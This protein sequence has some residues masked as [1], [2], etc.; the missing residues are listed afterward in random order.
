[1]KILNN[2][3]IRFAILSLFMVLGLMLSPNA[4][5]I[6][7][8]S[9]ADSQVI[10][11]KEQTENTCGEG[12]T[13]SISEDGV[14]TITGSGDMNSY[15]NMSSKRAP[16]YG[17]LEDI[18]EVVITGGV[19]S[20][21]SYAFNDLK[22]LTKVTL[23]DTVTTIGTYAFRNSG[24]TEFEITE[25]ISTIGKNAFDS[26]K[27]LTKV[28]IPKT[29]TSLPEGLFNGCSALETVTL[30]SGIKEIS[31]NLFS[32][33][34]ALFEVITEG[35]IETIGDTA[36][37]GCGFEKVTIPKSVTSIGNDAYCNCTKLKEV[38]IDADNATY[39][40]TARTTGLF[41]GC[42]ALETAT[43]NSNAIPTKEFTGC[44]ALKN[45]TI[46]E[47]ITEIES[48]AFENCA[49]LK[50]IKLPESLKKI[51][52]SAFKASGLEEITIPANVTCEANKEDKNTGIATYAFAKCN[53]LEKVIFSEGCYSVQGYA[54]SNASY[55]TFDDCANLK[56]IEI[57]ASMKSFIAYNFR[58]S[59]SLEKIVVD[60]KSESFIFE[61]GLLMD[62]NKTEVILA[63]KSEGKVVIPATVK[64][65]GTHAFQY[66][67]LTQA[68]LPDGLETIDTY[69]F[70]SCTNMQKVNLPD[71][72]K[73]ISQNSFSNSGILEVTIPANIT[74]LQKNTFNGCGNLKKVYIP[75]SVTSTGTHV[76]AN[77][78]SLSE[79]RLPENMSTIAS[80]LFLNCTSL[81]SIYLP[82]SVKIIDTN[83]FKGSTNLSYVYYAGQ[84]SDITVKTAKD[85]IN[86]ALWIY[87]Y[88]G[89][90]EN[91]EKATVS[92]I[93]AS[94]NYAQNDTPENLSVTV[95]SLAKEGENEQFCFTWF[96]N[97]KNSN[98][99]GVV[100]K[101]I[102]SQDGLTASCTPDTKDVGTNFYYVS[103]VRVV[104]GY[105][106]KVVV[107]EPVTITV[108]MAGLE[109]EG[110]EKNPFLL[111][112]Q[113]DLNLISSQVKAGN[114]LSGVYFAFANDISLD[115]NWEPIG[116]L[117]EGKTSANSGKDM[118]AFSGCID[119]ANHTL[120]I[121]KGGL[122]L[123]NYA[124][125]AQVKNLNIYGEYIKSSGLLNNYV[126]DYG[127]E[128]SADIYGSGVP[129]TLEVN[130]VTIKS[131]TV[132][133]ES[134]FAD[135]YA[136]GMNLINITNC[137]VEKNV[138]I[139]YDAEANA[140]T[141]RD[142]LTAVGS[143]G[144]RFNGHITNSVSYADVYG[145]NYV[146]GLTG[147]KGQ[148]MGDFVITN[149]SFHGNV[150]ATGDYA[151]GITGAGYPDGS[152]PNTR[153]ADIRNCYSDGNIS[154]NDYVAGIIG[155]EPVISQ[156]WSNGIGYICN[157]V[158]Y[159]KLTATKENAHMGGIISYIKSLNIYTNVD[160]NYFT[161]D[162]GAQKGIGSVLYVDTKA[163]HEN[164]QGVI[165]FSTE[166]TAAGCPEV[167]GCSW[168][169][170]HNR[171]DDPLGA[172]A[173]KLTK[174]VTKEILTN[175]S[176][177]NALNEGEYSS[178]NW[179]QGENA[180]KL[181][182]SPVIYKLEI[183]GDYKKE[184]TT[185]EDFDL[186]GAVVKGY[187]SDGTVKDIP[188]KDITVKGYD[189]NTKGQQIVTLN[190]NGLSLNV[191][192]TVVKPAV[193]TIKV[194][195]VVYGDDIHGGSEEDENIHTYSKRNLKI[196][197]E[198][199]EYEIPE[200]KTVWDLMAVV[201]EKHSNIVF[202]SKNNT[203]D[204]VHSVT[205]NG[206]ELGEFDNGQNSGWMY[207][208]NG[209]YPGVGVNAKYIEDGDQIIF[210]YTDDFT[211]EDEEYVVN[212]A[213]KNA[214][215]ELENYY[216]Y[217]DYRIEEIEKIKSIVKNAKEAINAASTHKAVAVALESAKNSIDKLKTD[218]QYNAEELVVI[219]DEAKTEIGSYADLSKYLKEQ[220]AKVEEIINTAL[221][222]IDAATEEE[223]VEKIL[224]D[225]KEAIDKIKTTEQLN[226]EALELANSAYELTLA[227]K[228][229]A[230]DAIKSANQAVN[231]ANK[232]KSEAQKKVKTAGDAAVK[233]AANYKQLALKAVKAEKNA[234]SKAK[235]YKEAAQ[236]AKNAA[237]ALLKL[238]TKENEEKAN[239]LNTIANNLLVNATTQLNKVTEAK[240]KADS[241]YNA[242][243]KLY[244]QAVKDRNQKNT[245]I[246]RAKAKK[247]NLTKVSILKGNRAS[248]QWKKVSGVSGYEI[249]YSLSSSF[250]TAKKFETRNILVKASE[251]KKTLSKLK[252]NKKY[253]VRVRT[254][255][256]ID[257]TKVY[258]KWSAKKAFTAKK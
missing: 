65:I 152:A 180:P 153:C 14:L 220:A 235:V 200:N 35:E 217:D 6:T 138:K 195:F 216:N 42:I 253:Y 73:E 75:D 39:V 229:I 188:V 36:F 169:I 190:Y 90:D 239:E 59:I 11:A 218:A 146:G 108:K 34:S 30:P 163:S 227:S 237:E 29:L 58:K 97:D 62:K 140:P 214:I 98:E 61:N 22:N 23:S 88:K 111:K 74:Q 38:V 63:T 242:A 201:M 174:Q 230:Q 101:T 71:S 80:S 178:H 89:T 160:N 248:I 222:S 167:Y 81:R 115:E 170:N 107:S 176:L 213:K 139:G 16:W 161:V 106:A 7:L 199:E 207:I 53:Q 221:N 215:T 26:C 123:L 147:R 5:N 114:N 2:K 165:Y 79:V 50:S 151:G 133:K 154:G 17:N 164:T 132:I 127:T 78:S 46:K 208:V 204:Y 55:M 247:V 124:R 116:A 177:V 246:K 245:L 112:S 1:M 27:S 137:T 48:S 52:G 240:N 92:S 15:A 96:K 145:R 171:N 86:N 202:N 60:E 257:K 191:T 148:A 238:V 31:K 231:N 250:K 21:G 143:F 41:S 85:D 47:G 57:P 54:S 205:F 234:L 70:D 3:T 244:N 224:S 45:V 103:I 211:I 189:K 173:N 10:N 87:G 172:D 219:K 241:A 83:G 156:C 20:I 223:E 51:S 252:N 24:I 113:E 94:N 228:D 66:N 104:N 249:Q 197:L 183:S 91:L 131:G 68:V 232:A 134:G 118:L 193:K 225:A 210:H 149:S 254:Y 122:P 236:S 255:K 129:S 40:T 166:N 192:V 209:S 102:L 93:S 110:T 233:S 67:F 12:L 64:K 212:E 158:F 136:S 37:K 76:F 203:G 8:A 82:L 251:V 179:V 28:T 105:A 117:K 49:A 13:Y 162:C 226:N 142:T 182:D 243:V 109:G 120:T 72:L 155:A 9:P 99:G 100:V 175:G 168:R 84:K 181:S 184:Y 144:G 32:G 128:D 125:T 206:I 185:G 69:A 186:S 130:N 187:V 56:T 119:G 135:G 258:G 196:W 194:H 256:V 19:N 18:K 4:K 44:A 159:G 33:C 141:A 25:N 121:A 43:I 198:D 126:I 95:N 150:I 77:C 157:N